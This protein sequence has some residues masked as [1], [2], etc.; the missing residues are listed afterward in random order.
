MVLNDTKE[1]IYAPTKALRNAWE[2]EYVG[3]KGS[4]VAQAKHLGAALKRSHEANKN[5][6]ERLKRT[7]GIANVISRLPGTGQ[8]R[9]SKGKLV[10]YASDLYGTEVEPLTWGQLQELRK[11]MGKCIWGKRNPRNLTA[12]LLLYRDKGDAEPY[13]AMVKRQVAHWSKMQREEVIPRDELEDI[14]KA[15]VADASKSKGPVHMIA[16]S[17]HQLGI[18]KEDGRIWTIRGIRWDGC[19]DAD[20]ID[21]VAQEA[22]RYVWKNK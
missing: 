18:Q 19:H 2:K 21:A 13:V 3:Y 6:P 8:S 7:K 14:W 12:A 1:Q 16:N 17:S 9:C 10:I 20:A 22:V 4:V 5:A 11:Q 15:S